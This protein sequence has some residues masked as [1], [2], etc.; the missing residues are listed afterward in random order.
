MRG[1]ADNERGVVKGRPPQAQTRIIGKT[2][3]F[4]GD[5]EEVLVD[6][7]RIQIV[8]KGLNRIETRGDFGDLNESVSKRRRRGGGVGTKG[9]EKRVARAEFYPHVTTGIGHAS[10]MH[11]NL[12]R[13]GDAGG[14]DGGRAQSEPPPKRGG[15]KP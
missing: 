5:T 13:M 9:G 3:L 6:M 14:A 11:L 10:D 12:G 7:A 2:D 8:V 1:V 4:S 15:A